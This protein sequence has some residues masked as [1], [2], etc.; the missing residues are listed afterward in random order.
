MKIYIIRNCDCDIL[1]TTTSDLSA[2]Y[3]I[4]KNIISEWLN[5]ESEYNLLKM[6]K[7]VQLVNEKRYK[8]AADIAIE[9]DDYV[10]YEVFDDENHKPPKLTKKFLKYLNEETKEE[11]FK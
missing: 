11:I 8:E 7:M 3:F 6:N 10:S 2:Y 4:I 5:N 9:I 1:Y